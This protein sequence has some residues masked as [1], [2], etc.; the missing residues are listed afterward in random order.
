MIELTEIMIEI[1]WY[2]IKWHRPAQIPMG[3]P[4]CTVTCTRSFWSRAHETVCLSDHV[5]SCR[6]FCRSH[7]QISGVDN[8]GLP[9]P[10]PV[11][12]LCVTLSLFNDRKKRSVTWQR[13][14]ILSLSRFGEQ[15][16]V[17]KTQPEFGS[18]NQQADFR[19]LTLIKQSQNLPQVIHVQCCCVRDTLSDQ[20]SQN[21]Q[22]K[23]QSW[24]SKNGL[25]LAFFDTQRHYFLCFRRL[26]TVKI[27]MSESLLESEPVAD[28]M[29]FAHLADRQFLSF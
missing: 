17:S 5:H 23:N 3:H 22:R 16:D 18:G 13:T 19:R 7:D 1:D 20:S 25:K 2:G 28:F 29:W 4:D 8:F 14:V 21:S 10:R 12:V 11:I 15:K 26:T 27:R 9:T 6:L 24:L